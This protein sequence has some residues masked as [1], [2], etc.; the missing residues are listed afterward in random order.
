MNYPN[1]VLVNEKGLFF[2]FVHENM[3]KREFPF[4]VSEVEITE[5]NFHQISEIQKQMGAP[6]LI[7]GAFVNKKEELKDYLVAPTPKTPSK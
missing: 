1:K 6:V 7:D 5:E 4:E 3:P 2:G